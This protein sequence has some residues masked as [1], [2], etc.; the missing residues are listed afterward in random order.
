MMTTATKTQPVPAA[1][2]PPKR[3]VF[4]GIQPTGRSHIG[5]YLGAMKNWVRDQQQFD[6][7]FC[8]VDLHA[9]T[10]AFDPAEL[11]RNTREMAALLLAVGLDPQYCHIFVQSHVAAHS[12]MAW[13]LN[14]V[15]PVGW[16]E[17]MTQYK[18]KAQKQ[19]SVMTGLLDYPVLMAGDILLYHTHF[20]PVGEDQKQ[21]VEL[22]RDIAQSF[23]A[24]FG[25][26]FTIP[27]P[28]IPP[29]GARIMSLTEPTRKMSKSDDDL[30]GSIFL[31][32]PPDA[33]RR[34]LARATTDSQRD[35]VFDEKRAGIYNLL[36]LY[37]LFS[38][39]PR[40]QIEVRFAGKGYG[41]FKQALA[42]VVVEG[43]RPLQAR[44]A[45]LTR[46]PG[47]LDAILRQGA[48]FCA[49]IAN[50]TL[51]DTQRAMGLR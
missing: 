8:I 36:T 37:E 45:D 48:E 18:D 21:H 13:L 15:T 24:R 51:L 34:K 11:R 1:Q 26:V 46:D 47:T 35:I 20:V 27:E 41:D 39:E 28:V 25:E 42:D 32:D 9:I 31:L 38:G 6:N 16:L 12:E 7:F 23:N 19:V 33:I 22:A 43:L 14:G 3:R 10:V 30:N 2:A 29:V 50:Q 4:S 17:R 49:A 40:A 5:N 44:Y